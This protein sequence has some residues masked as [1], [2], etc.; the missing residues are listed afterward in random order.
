MRNDRNVILEL[1]LEAGSIPA[2][3]RNKG[4]YEAEPAFYKYDI[5]IQS[6]K[7][8]QLKSDSKA[9]LDTKKEHLSKYTIS[10]RL[11]L[12][13]SLEYEL[14]MYEDELTTEYNNQVED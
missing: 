12:L 14:S 2:E 13:S 10:E 3:N 11:F 8:I 9:I 1:K 6:E 4:K 7:A 5:G